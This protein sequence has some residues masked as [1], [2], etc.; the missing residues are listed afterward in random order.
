MGSKNNISNVKNES[1]NVSNARHENRMELSDRLRTI[2]SDLNISQTKFANTLGVSFTY[3]NCL[4]N[5]KR[6]NISQS[7][8]ILIQ[9]IY[10][11]SAQWILFEEGSVLKKIIQ[12]TLKTRTRLIT[13]LNTLTKEEIDMVIDHIEYVIKETVNNATNELSNVINI[14]EKGN[15]YYS[16]K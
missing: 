15:K 1:R 3:I 2:V 12:R 14:K 8:A 4:L 10:G 9:Y 6:E 5:G 11:Y 13:V 7:L 16:D